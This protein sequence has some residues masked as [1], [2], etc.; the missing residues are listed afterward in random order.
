MMRSGFIVWIIPQKGDSKIFGI[1]YPMPLS[2]LNLD[3]VERQ[4][5]NKDMFQPEKMQEMFTKM[6]NEKNEFQVINEDNFPLGQYGLE[7]KEGIKAKLGYKAEQFIYELQ[8]PLGENKN[9][10]YQIASLPGDK[11]KIKFETLESE[12][13][14]VPGEGMGRGMKPPVGGA[15]GGEEEDPKSASGGMRKGEGGKF[16]RPEPFN[17]KVELQLRKQ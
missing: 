4:D 13:G 17:Y 16:S 3:R 10:L 9:Y 14:G 8:I 1:K 6:L 5:F 11:L 7:N 2:L 15:P 12:F